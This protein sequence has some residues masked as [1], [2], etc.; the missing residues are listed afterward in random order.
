[1]ELHAYSTNSRTVFTDRTLLRTRLTI[2]SATVVSVLYI[3]HS[4]IHGLV[5]LHFF[6]AAF[7]S[8][9][10]NSVLNIHGTLTEE[11]P[12]G[13]GLFTLSALMSSSTYM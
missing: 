5:H 6:C 4:H 10:H 1:M 7:G 12:A 3:N 13:I 2:R 9:D 8:S 11:L